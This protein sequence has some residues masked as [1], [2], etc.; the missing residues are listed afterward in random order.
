VKAQSAIE[1]LTTYG[2]MLVVVA[3]IGGVIYPLIGSQ[4]IQG[5][6]G[7]QSGP[8]NIEDSAFTSGNDLSLE[9]RNSRARDIRIQ[10]IVAN[11]NDRERNYQVSENI[12]SGQQDVTS[13]P[14]FEQ[15]ESCEQVELEVVYSIGSLNDL[16]TT[17]E[18]VGQFRFNNQSLP[19]PLDAVN[20]NY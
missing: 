6:T 17:G 8:L 15:S 18:V 12:S 19:Q 7:F 2:W 10:E 11:V 16:Q 3:I 5:S 9:I 1:Y 14:A 13:L 4:C 20:V